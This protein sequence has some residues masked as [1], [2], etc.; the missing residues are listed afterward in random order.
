MARR[1]RGPD[2]RGIEMADEKK[3]W[4]PRKTYGWGWGLPI[5]WQGRMAWAL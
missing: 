4:F 1:G 3:Y 2:L 5:A